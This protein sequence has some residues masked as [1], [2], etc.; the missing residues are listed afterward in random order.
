MGNI[1][2]GGSDKSGASVSDSDPS[3]AAVC[4]LL[5]IN[6]SEFRKWMMKKQIITRN[7]KIISNLSSSQ[8][9]VVRDSAAKFLYSNLFDW[10]IKRTNEKL[11]HPDESQI[12][13]F[14]GVLDIYGF[15]HFAKNSFEQFCI[16]YAN[17]KLQQQFN[18]HVFKLEQEEYIKEKIN[19]TFIDFSD[20]KP[21]IEIIESK[22]GV[23]SLLDEQ[24]RLPSGSDEGFV[25]KLYETLAIP[26]N[27]KY[28]SKPRFG[29]TAFTI[30]HYAHDVTYESENFLEKNRD[31]VPD[32]IL[33]LFQNTQNPF[34]KEV[35][36]QI[37]SP[38]DSPVSSHTLLIES[39]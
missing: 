2:I 22:L 31:T 24:S 1:A 12:R 37:T 35:V 23:L 8:A 32:E 21:C 39:N 20:N 30:S 26:K 5:E 15:E 19:W 17:E 34:L 13:S 7:D 11:S 6:K 36:P 28:F 29:N 9:T 10:L 14:I 16:N 3:L 38:T 25:G 4:Q 27:E 33:A 18:Q